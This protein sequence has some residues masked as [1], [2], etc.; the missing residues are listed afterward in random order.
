MWHAAKNGFGH[1]FEPLVQAFFFS[2]FLPMAT[3]PSECTDTNL[4]SEIHVVINTDS[5]EK[6]VSQE[7][8]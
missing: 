4:P 3:L 5:K 8:G 2:F 6:S 1:L 7:P